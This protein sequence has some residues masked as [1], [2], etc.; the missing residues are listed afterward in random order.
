MLLA[1]IHSNLHLQG[2]QYLNDLV[3]YFKA[4]SDTYKAIYFLFGL[5]SIEMLKKYR[6]SENKEYKYNLLT[7]TLFYYVLSLI[8][9]EHSE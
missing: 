9:K 3:A 7:Q 2:K 6:I 4:P 1:C 5:K 8:Q